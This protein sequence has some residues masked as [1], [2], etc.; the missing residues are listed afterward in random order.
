MECQMS[1]AVLTNEN[2]LDLDRLSGGDLLL[3][4]DQ[5]VVSAAVQAASA[6]SDAEPNAVICS[7]AHWCVVHPS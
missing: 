6:G 1:T 2:D 7:K 4:E 3:K 5:A